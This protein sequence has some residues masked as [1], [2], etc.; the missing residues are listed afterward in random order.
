MTNTRCDQPSGMRVHPQGHTWLRVTM[1]LLLSPFRM[2]CPRPGGVGVWP[3]HFSI[4][5]ARQWLL[6][7]THADGFMN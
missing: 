2:L 7:A 5:R 1:Q 6:C 4:K 3:H